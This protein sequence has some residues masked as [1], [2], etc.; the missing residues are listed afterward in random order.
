MKEP[1]DQPLQI[2][3]ARTHLQKRCSVRWAYLLILPAKTHLQKRCTVRWAD[4]QILL[5]RSHLHKRCTVRWAD[6]QILLANT[7]F[8]CSYG[9]QV[10]FLTKKESTIRIDNQN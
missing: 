9:A 10:E 4:L 6:L 7:V 3:L 8:A 5:A 2:L 1:W